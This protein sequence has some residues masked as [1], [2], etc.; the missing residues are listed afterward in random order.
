[1]VC[2]MMFYVWVRMFKCVVEEFMC[3]CF[4]VFFGECEL[5]I[6]VFE[7]LWLVG[8][9]VVCKKQKIDKVVFEMVLD[10]LLGCSVFVVFD[11][12]FILCL[13]FKDMIEVVC[14]NFDC[15]VEGDCIV[16]MIFDICVW[17]VYY[18]MCDCCVVEVGFDLL[19]GSF[20][21]DGCVM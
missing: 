2:E 18:F 13:Y 17:F 21:G 19:E 4:C 16:L 11:Q 14:N 1:M 3:D 5:L 8:F 7:E 6:V 10:V 12:F 15:F 20:D 9:K